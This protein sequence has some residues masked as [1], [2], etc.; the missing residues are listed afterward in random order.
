MLIC[1]HQLNTKIEGYAKILHAGS[2]NANIS[3]D[4]SQQATKQFIVTVPDSY[5]KYYAI[6]TN[7]CTVSGAGTNGKRMYVSASVNE[8][9]LAGTSYGNIGDVVNYI[10][11]TEITTVNAGDKIGTNVLNGSDTTRTLSAIHTYVL[12]FPVF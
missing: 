7:K 12:L 3:L 10:S 6:I 9:S 11:N 8:T 2:D 5:D 4:A 1:S